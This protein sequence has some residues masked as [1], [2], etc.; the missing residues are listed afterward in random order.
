MKIVHFVPVLGKG[1]AERVVV[2]LANQ[3]AID[4]HEV[5]IV[6][7]M[8]APPELLPNMLRSDIPIRYLDDTDDRR[9]RESGVPP[10]DYLKLLVWVARNRKWLLGRDIVHCHLSMGSAFGAAVQLLRTVYRRS[11]PAVVETYHA[12]GVAIPDFHRAVHARFLSRRDSVAFMAEDAY[13]TRYRERRLNRLFRT[14]PNGIAA[15]APIDPEASD[16]YRQEVAGIPKNAIVLGSVGRLVAER[17]PDLLLEMFVRLTKITAGNVHLLLA[18]EGPLRASLEETSRRHGLADRVHLPGLILN[19]VEAFGTIDLYLTVN[20][21]PITGIAAIE[22]ASS[23]LPIVALQ[24]DRHHQTSASDWIWS[25][26]DPQKAAEHVAGLLDK[27][28]E[29]QSLA[30]RQESN[31][32]SKHGIDAMAKAYYSLYGDAL[33]ARGADGA[34]RQ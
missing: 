16:H 34:V 31:V 4:G 27:P 8:P 22:A 21:G 20:V 15:A 2:D 29:L 33:A 14:I 17:R 24:L 7:W 11:A 6:A 28:A 23:G 18:G 1:G 25:S 26:P 32:R 30:E 19:P 10:S 9:W 12:V 13:W 3:A 5:S